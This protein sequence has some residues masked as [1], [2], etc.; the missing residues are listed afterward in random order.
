M[1]LRVTR[2]A[3]PS[4][5]RRLAGLP[6]DRAEEFPPISPRPP[7]ERPLT[8]SG[9]SPY[10]RRS[11]GNPVARRFLLRRVGCGPKRSHGAS[12]IATKVFP[13]T[14]A[15]SSTRLFVRGLAATRGVRIEE[16]PD[17]PFI[18]PVAPDVGRRRS[19]RW[20]A[21]GASASGLTRLHL[22]PITGVPAVGSN[23]VDAMTNLTIEYTIAP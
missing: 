22:P 13:P 6:P 2:P 21:P 3:E 23:F 11:G 10:W 16:I 20:P 5:I 14:E 9:R 7:P 4:G 8:G 18:A 12:Q 15:G 17:A 19:P 1:S